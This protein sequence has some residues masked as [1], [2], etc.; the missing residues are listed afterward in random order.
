M[1]D[2]RIRIRIAEH[3]FQV[4][5]RNTIRLLEKGNK[6]RVTIFFKGREIT[7]PQFGT[8]LLDKMVNGTKDIANVVTRVEKDRTFFVV[9][10]PQNER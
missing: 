10:E 9:L 7:Y 5:L 8:Q 4:K 1:K 2:I 3:D 6:V